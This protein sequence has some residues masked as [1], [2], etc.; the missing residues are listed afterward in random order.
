MHNR[1]LRAYTAP[2][3]FSEAVR[4]WLKAHYGATARTQIA[5]ETGV[6][7]STVNAFL[8]GSRKYV[9]METIDQLFGGHRGPG[10]VA[11]R[12]AGPQAVA[13]GR[14]PEALAIA[15]AFDRSDESL[16]VAVRAILASHG[17]PFAL[18][19]RP[20]SQAPRVAHKKKAS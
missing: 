5:K 12:D 2:V 11:V 13:G 18:S 1:A 14:S 4:N 10:E 9:S 7:V 19:R 20:S 6:S 17:H 8:K 16:K 15:D 3:L